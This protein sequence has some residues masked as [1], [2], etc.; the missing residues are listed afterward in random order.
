MR[1][2]FAKELEK[3]MELDSRIW[4]FVGDVGYGVFDDIRKKFPDRFINCGVA[5][6]SMIGVAVGL[7]QSGKIPFVYSITP[8]LLYRPYEFIRTLIHHDETNVKLI[9]SG[10]DDDYGDHNYTHLNPEDKQIMKTLYNIKSYWPESKKEIYSLLKEMIEN[11]SPYYL[12][13]KR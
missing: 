7:A 11:K 1:K 8:F 13:M 10:R 12:N 9:S 6:Q 5:E 4:L 3:A 2:T